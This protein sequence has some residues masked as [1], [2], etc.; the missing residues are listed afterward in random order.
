MAAGTAVGIS[1]V[2]VVAAASALNPIL[3]IATLAGGLVGQWK[4]QDKVASHSMDKDEEKKMK[5]FLRTPDGKRMLEHYKAAADLGME[6]A[7]KEYDFLIAL[8]DKK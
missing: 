7:K 8:M 6:E 2:G 4:I 5:K 1:T 3:G